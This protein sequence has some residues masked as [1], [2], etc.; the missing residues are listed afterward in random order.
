MVRLWDIASRRNLA[1]FRAGVDA[2]WSVAISP[3]GRRL[4]A[5]TGDGA[6]VVW[7]VE[8]RQHLVTLKGHKSPIVSNL[9][10][11]PDGTLLSVSDRDICF[12]RRVPMNASRE[13]G[14]P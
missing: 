8:S 3:D 10:F 11:S 5:G 9:R 14:A 13:G 4:C 6:V 7:D 12:W 1:E 2:F